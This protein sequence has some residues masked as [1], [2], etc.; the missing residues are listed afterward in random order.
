M[1]RISVLLSSV[2]VVQTVNTV[3]VDK[4]VTCCSQFSFTLSFMLWYFSNPWNKIRSRIR[5]T[6]KQAISYDRRISTPFVSQ[7]RRL[8]KK[9][10]G[11]RWEDGKKRK[12]AIE[13]KTKEARWRKRKVRDYRKEKRETFQNKDEEQKRTKRT[14]KNWLKKERWRRIQRQ[15][16]RRRRKQNFL[17]FCPETKKKEQEEEEI[18]RRQRLWKSRRR[19][20]K[21]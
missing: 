17:S 1:S 10:M 21:K 8:C 19:E 12:K 11:S 18:Q 15:R 4:R 3:H 16:R 14:G 7:D 20:R 9:K 2:F 13:K 6:K 5:K